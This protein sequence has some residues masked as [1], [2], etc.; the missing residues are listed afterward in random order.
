MNISEIKPLG[1]RLRA[2]MAKVVVGQAATVDLL[3]IAL[4]AGG[5]ILLEG[6]PGIAKTLLAQ[7]FAALPGARIR[8]HPVHARPDAG[9][10]YWA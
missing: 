8:P 7:T 2:E 9:W 4:F 6:P 10:S 5:H 3:L 1:D